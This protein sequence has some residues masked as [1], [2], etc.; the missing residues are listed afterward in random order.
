MKYSQPYPV[1][2]AE[3]NV[4]DLIFIQR[5]IRKAN[6]PFS[7]QVVSNGEEAVRYLLGEEQ[8]ADRKLYPFPALLISNMKMPRMNGLELLAWVKQQPNFQNLPVIVMSSSE[9]PDEMSQVITLGG[10]AYFVK[11]SCLDMLSQIVKKMV[12]FLP[13]QNQEL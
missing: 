5:A 6:V 1:L 2:L 8:Y 13:E 4:A 7:L 9:D 12:S 11:T 3:D 10:S